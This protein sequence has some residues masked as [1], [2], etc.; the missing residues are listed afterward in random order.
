MALPPFTD[1]GDLPSGVHPAT[2]S[3]VLVR[4]GAGSAQRIAVG[5][6]LERIYRVATATGQVARF[7]VFGSFVT[8][9][10]E[11][12]DVDV[13]FLMED[14]FD[15]SQL[16]GEARLLFDHAAAQVHFGASVFWIRRLAAWEGEQ[17]TVEYWQVKRGDGR[18][19]ILEIIPE[20]P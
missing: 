15:S 12:E 2:L 14:T 10:P 5:L 1:E 13:F 8:E 20:A 9:K 11:P 7:V 4:F 3:E 16:T 19:G 6:R 17:A 18:R